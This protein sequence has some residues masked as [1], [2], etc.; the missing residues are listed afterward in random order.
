MDGPKSA[1]SSW[2]RCLELS[3][4]YLSVIV[5]RGVKLLGPEG[6]VDKVL[7]DVPERLLSAAQGLNA[8]AEDM[9]ARAPF[10]RKA[11]QIL[12]ARGTLTDRDLHT[13]ILT[14]KGLGQTTEALEGYRILL[15]RDP[16]QV[17][18]HYELAQALYEGG[19]LNEARNE[20]LAILATQ[21]RHGQAY[22]LLMNVTKG[23]LRRKS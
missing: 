19:R 2:R 21:P 10:L 11:L 8:P 1:W 3:D 17:G 4:R 16:L 6:V 18:W 22:D 9:E 5:D 20:L 14:H 23:L 7:P 13:K 12:K 15:T